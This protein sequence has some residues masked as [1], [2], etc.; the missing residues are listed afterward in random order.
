MVREKEKTKIKII[1]KRIA[2]GESF[3][4]EGKI[5]QVLH[6][7]P[8]Y[9]SNGGSDKVSSYIIDLLVEMG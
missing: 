2:L 7:E 9:S 3:E 5:I 8:I 1:R 4:I 6:V